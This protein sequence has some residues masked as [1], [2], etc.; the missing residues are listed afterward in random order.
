MSCSCSW[1]AATATVPSP[2][3]AYITDCSFFFFLIRLLSR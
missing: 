3:A 1:I 2:S